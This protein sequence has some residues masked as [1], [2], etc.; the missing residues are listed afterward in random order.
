V[1]HAAFAELSTHSSFSDERE[2]LFT[3]G[4]MF[5]IENVAYD[6]DIKVW[7]ILIS[8]V[9]EDDQRLQD[10]YDYKNWYTLSLASQI[11]QV[12][13]LIRRVASQGIR[14]S[15]FYY[16]YLLKELPANNTCCAVC[17]SDLGWNAYIEGNYISAISYQQKALE[18][19]GLLKSDEQNELL[20]VIFNT[21]GVVHHRM[22]N[23]M[24][25]SIIA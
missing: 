10:C 25:Y 12:G 22:Q 15:G 24:P 3:A 7:V 14:V 4:S 23:Y 16:N 11:S 8:L 5:R 9:G 17:Y 18:L 6:T 20:S 2:V 1:K 21:F 13:H 19:C